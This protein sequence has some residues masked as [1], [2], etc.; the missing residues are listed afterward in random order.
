MRICRHHLYTISLLFL[1]NF[2]Y[3]YS[4]LPST[5]ITTINNLYNQLLQ[6][7][8]INRTIDWNVST[9]PCSWRGVFCTAN[10]S[11]ITKLSLSSL[12]ISNNVNNSWSSLVCR[13]ETL[14]D[15][16][17]SDNQLTSIP[18]LFLSS[19]SCGAGLK[20]LNISN[21]RLS[22]NLDTFQGSLQVLD[23]SHNL[24]NSVTIDSQFD[25]LN[26]LR[27]LNISHNNFTGSIPSK[28]GK[29]MLF[30]ELQLSENS[31]AG[32]IS[33]DITKYTNLSLI[34]LSVNKLTGTIPELSKLSKLQTLVLS[35][36]NLVGEIPQS[37][38]TLTFLKR[39]AANL[40]YFT[41]SIPQ[42]ITRYL[43]NLDLSYNRLNGSIPNDLLSQPNLLAV[44]LTS[45][46]LNGSLPSNMST[47]LVRLRL[48]SNRFSGPI[49]SWSFGYN[50]VLSLTYLE[51]DNNSLSGVIPSGLSLFKN[52]TL[53]DLSNNLLVGSVP[54]ELGELN[55]LQVLQLQNNKL[56]GE[57]PYEV[58]NLQM[59]EKL[60][61]SSNSLN[62]SLPSSLSRLRK[63]TNLELQDNELTGEI[64]DSFADMNSLLELQLGSNK[65][66]GIIRLLPTKLQIALNLS[67]NNFF[68]SIP[69][70]LARLQDLE[71]LDLSNNKF[72]GDIPGFLVQMRSLTTIVLSN[73]LLTGTVPQF[74]SNVVVL[75]EGNNVS[76]VTQNSFKRGSPNIKKPVFVGIIVASTVAVVALM[77]VVVWVLV[78]SKRMNK[79]NVEEPKCSPPQVIKSK[80]LTLNV[81]HRTYVDFAKSVEAAVHA[82][83]IVLKTRLSTYYKAVM[84][85][86]K[87]YFVKKV[88]WSDKMVQLGSHDLFE[89]E[90]EVV[91]R[92]RN[93]S[94]MIPLGYAL[95][96]DSAYLL[97]EYNEKGNLFD[98]LHGSLESDLDWANRY[99]VAIGIANGLAF[100]H[101]NPTGPIILLDLS[102]KAIMLKSLNEPLIGD[103]ELSKVIDP[104]KST[105]N[106][107]ALAGSVGY[108]P[109]EYAY[110][111]RVTTA[112]NVYSFGVILLELLTGKAAVSE[113][114]ELAKWVSSQLDNLDK[115]LDPTVS[116]TSQATKGMMLMVLKVA[117][118]CVNVS[119]EARPKMKSVLRMLL[120]ARN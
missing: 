97:Y 65:L 96:T 1:F 79:V 8:N 25:E 57:I 6:S 85:S 78:V 28:L 77:V 112:G 51:V 12:S 48:G 101:E 102:S 21:N 50:V 5:Q 113:G 73:N 93:S 83:N 69:N 46:T 115:V 13:L 27:S 58:G 14:T 45:N 70:S 40:N 61:M 24:F 32:P 43:T 67:H 60:N 37:I 76:N 62:G 47:S 20:L 18:P 100:L 90:L 34:D 116:G 54:P 68:G 49:P 29:S 105:E 7:S 74:G 55:R 11:S 41:G 92:L 59:L 44:D 71:V 72:S 66:G 114:S 26:E 80:L 118:A 94:V 117:S 4:E 103:I 88:N 89:Q 110:T 120:N 104:S 22:G 109:P 3:V 39:F 119:P 108:I 81:I 31:F 86:G 30:Q 9:N 53:L 17:L 16:D 15:I 36:N 2:Q 19:S 98:A 91:G 52:L 82:S 84:P 75:T 63:L 33:I 42:G 95:T 64:P 111:M 106:L 38:S 35:V 56:F 99:S 87:I 23:L 10:N 107:S